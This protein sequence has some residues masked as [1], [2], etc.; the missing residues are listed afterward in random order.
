M[1]LLLAGLLGFLAAAPALAADPSPALKE[2][3]AAASK[4]GKLDIQWASNLVGGRDGL[5]AMTDGMNAMFGTKIELRFTPGPNLND[6]MNTI[7]LSADAGR[8]SPTDLAIGSNQHASELWKRGVSLKVDWKA[9]LPDRIQ[10]ESIEADG[11]AIRVFTT[12][13][14]G[15]VYNP[16]KVP[17]PPTKLTDLLKPEWKGK[18]AST[19]YAS[20]F[21]LLAA[22][23][24]WGEEKALE[25]ARTLS[26]Q[27]SGLIRCNEL[28][29]IASGEF[30]AYEMDC[31]GRE[32]LSLARA[33]APVQHVVPEDLPG[34]RFYYMVVPKNSK[35]PNAA[36]LFITFLE[37]HEGQELIW[38]YADTDLHTYPDG[39]MWNEVKAYEDK[40]I[41]F[42]QF[43]IEWF[44]AHPEALATLRKVIPILTG[45]AQ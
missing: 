15:I 34:Q 8:P 27:I 29:R 17:Y 23:D 30:I 2:V 25:F 42:K 18:I 37:T 32:W 20:G 44:N 11:T 13:P 22:S 14:G 40:G 10:A 26:K 35:A 21:D 16:Q 6:I 43:T 38:K 19:P 39:H 36:E 12:L 9:L 24:M 41:K 7:V 45:A 28:E 1:K 5:K 3:I 31:I 4:E 33:G